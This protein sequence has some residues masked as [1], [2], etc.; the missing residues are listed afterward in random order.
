MAGLLMTAQYLGRLPVAYIAITFS[1]FLMLFANP[2][3]L[4]FDI[5]F[6]LS[7]LAIFGLIYLQPYFYKWLKILPNPKIF[8]ARSTLS[9]TLAAQIFVLP[10]LVYNFGNIP[11]FSPVTN[12]LIVP[13]IAPLTIFLFIF[14][15]LGMIFSSLGYLLSL[16]AWLFLSYIVIIVKWFSD[17]PLSSVTLKNVHWIWVLISYLILGFFVW[18]LEKKKWPKILKF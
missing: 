9:A 5:G 3:L 13:F 17:L 15:I 8:Q 16:P 18:Q 10:I 2:L 12:I 6:Q 1:L 4:K 7:F 14:G 11:L